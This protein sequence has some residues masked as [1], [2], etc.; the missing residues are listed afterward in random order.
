MRRR[1]LELRRREQELRR[2]E[3]GLKAA[4]ELSQLKENERKKDEDNKE[5]DNTTAGDDVPKAEN[6]RK[7]DEDGKTQEV[8][9]TEQE[10]LWYAKMLTDP[11]E[12]EIFRAQC[13]LE[14]I[15]ARS[16]WAK[17]VIAGWEPVESL[18]ASLEP[19]MARIRDKYAASPTG[20]LVAVSS[21]K[22]TP[23][24]GPAPAPTDGVVAQVHASENL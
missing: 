20:D 9:K 7:K 24:F 15:T 17:L 3:Q 14:S 4:E 12:R 13:E 10:G 6:E 16:E 23:H 1:E 8:L 5:E 21:S 11:D 22:E 18:R 2:W 19:V